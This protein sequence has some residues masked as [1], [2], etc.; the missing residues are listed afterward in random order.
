MKGWS[1]SIQ[2]KD[3]RAEILQRLEQQAVNN[4]WLFFWILQHSIHVRFWNSDR[5]WLL[6]YSIQEHPIYVFTRGLNSIFGILCSFSLRSLSRY[7]YFRPYKN[8]SPSLEKWL[9]QE[10]AIV[11]WS[12]R[13][14]PDFGIPEHH[15]LGPCHPLNSL[16]YSTMCYRRRIK[17]TPLQ[18]IHWASPSPRQPG[19]RL[20]EG[21]Q[22]DKHDY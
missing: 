11:N 16:V 13:G 2:P 9:L 22:P 21:V 6:L 18:S 8:I 14:S 17:F 19:K 3:T 20:S 15:I 5:M 10:K 4:M 7:I 1:K 12:R